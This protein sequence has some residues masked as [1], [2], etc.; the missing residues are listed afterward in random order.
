M[1]EISVQLHSWLRMQRECLPLAVRADALLRALHACPEVRQAFFLRWQAST[2]TYSYEGSAPHLP[3]GFGDPLEASDQLLFE[4]LQHEPRLELAALRQL[5]CWLAGRVRRAGLSHGQAL[6]LALDEGQADLLLIEL[7]EQAGSDWLGLVHQLLLALLATLP[8]QARGS[9]LLGSDPQPSLLLDSEAQPLQLNAAMQALL[10]ERPLAV[11]ADLL[12]VN[13]AHLVRA[14]LQQDRAIEAVEAQ[15]AGQVLMWTFMPDAAEQQVLARCRPATA[16][17]QAER[18]AAKASRLYRLITENTTD[19]ISR[20]TPDGRFL[21]A[22]PASWTLLGYWPEEL[23]GTLVQALFHEQD[24]QHLVDST[25]EALEQDGYH[26]MTY[27][28]RR[29]DGHYLWF[30]TA[31]R[32]IRETYTGAVVEVVSVSRDITARVLAEENKRRL[33]EVVEANTDLVLF[34]DPDGH[35]THLNPSARHA[36]NIQDDQPLPPLDQLLAASDFQ[37]LQQHGWAAADT[38]GVW[39]AEVQLLP[40]APRAPLPVSLVLLA[41]RG[42]DGEHYYSLVARDMTERELREAEQRRHQDELAHTARLVTLGEL[43]SGIAHEINQPLAAVVN[44]ASA[45]QRYLKAL[46]D[47]PEAAD[48]VA[49]GLERINEHA[50][51]ASEVIKR[52]R[53]FLR[54]GQRR[55][56]ALD[57]AS[58]ARE[59]VRLCQWE[60][61]NWQVTIAEQLAD[62]LPRVYADR[63]LLEQ[64]LLNLLRNAIDANREA[65]PGQASRI[66]LSAVEQDGQLCV[67]VWDQGPGVAQGELEHIFTPFYTSKAEGLGLGLSMSRSILEGFGGALEAHPGTAGGLCLECRLPL[68]RG[69]GVEA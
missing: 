52:L 9:L 45:S 69:D 19:L 43:A 66:E 20:H 18:D 30:E 47:N 57:I 7:Q 15:Y 8:Q 32:G 22:S 42:R 3:P 34:I 53:A 60:A 13:A 38:A 25:R 39:S 59:A 29:R 12:P 63:V 33:A 46:G 51:H 21:D 14:C 54:K 4:R 56:Q 1:N 49:Q 55:T 68:L 67:R 28:I 48:K 37:Q 27:R 10:G 2:A 31:S 58:V 16:Q 44:Y 36:L 61:S 17:V 40:L 23:R 65:H 5:P 26:T 11:V 35:L 50:K 41:H 6:A 64:V 24:Q 62:N